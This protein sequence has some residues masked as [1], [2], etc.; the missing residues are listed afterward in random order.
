MK[1]NLFV[2]LTVFMVVFGSAPPLKS[3]SDEP[4][5][6]VGH[7]VTA[8]RPLNHPNP[9]YSK[10]ARKAGLQGK[11]VL[12]VVVNSEGKPENVNVSRSLGMGLN[13]KAVEAV[14]SWTFEPARKDGKPVAVQI[15]VVVTFRIGIGKDA[16][17]PNARKALE[18]AR[19]EGAEFRR[20]AW[21]R[22]YRAE[23]ATSAPLCQFAFK[24]GEDAA[25]LSI[26]GLKTGVRQYRLDSINFTNNRAIA[27]AAALRS[28]FPI[29]DGEPFDPIKVADG[30]RQL[31]T[32]YRIQGFV[33]FK[34]SVEPRIDE[35]RRS[36]ALQIECSEGRQFVVDHV[37]I[38]GLDEHTFE[39]VRKSLYVKPGDVYNERLANLWLEKNSR[40]TTPDT[41]PSERIK[42]GAD[43]NVGT[44]VMT[45]DFR[46]CAE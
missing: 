15:S 12:S 26:S 30:L 38:E 20:T 35:T 22:V 39:K 29:K 45:Y 16:M 7:G 32:A 19:K 21:K 17:T 37:N 33:S 2:A 43:E 8:P 34:S 28:L 41:S 14:R 36:I 10:E 25:Q 44:V 13:E 42:L 24:Q 40:L 6:R 11:C 4:V 23:S 3:Q 5:L 9:E 1:S 27:N 46:R 18:R 31:R